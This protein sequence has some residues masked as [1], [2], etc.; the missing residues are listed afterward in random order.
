MRNCAYRRRYI[1]TH[2]TLRC[3]AVLRTGVAY[4]TLGV[5]SNAQ[6]TVVA[7]IRYRLFVAKKTS[8]WLADQIGVSVFWLSRRF[9]GKPAFRVNELEQIA[10]A[11]GTDFESLFD[12]PDEVLN[13]RIDDSSE[14]H[15]SQMPPALAG[16]RRSA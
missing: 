6:T 13:E 1:V 3:I 12:V 9:A 2:A 4:A 10:E 5:M 7:G 8:K 11:L 16:D 15:I 14:D